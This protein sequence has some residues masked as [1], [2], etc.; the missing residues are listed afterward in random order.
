VFFISG[1]D[2]SILGDAVSKWI[3]KLTARMYS[4]AR[5]EVGLLNRR[6]RLYA[7]DSSESPSHLSPAVH[8][9]HRAYP[10]FRSLGTSDT[11]CDNDI[12]CESFKFPLCEVNTTAGEVFCAKI[13]NLTLDMEAIVD[14]LGPI[15][16]K[17]VSVNDED[18]AG[19]LDK[20]VDPALL[21]LDERL[22]GISDIL[23]KKI[24]VLDIAELFLGAKSGAPTVRLLIKIYRSIKSFATRYCLFFACCICVMLGFV[25]I[26][27][28]NVPFPLLLS[29]FSLL[30]N[31]CPWF[32]FTLK[33][34]SKME[35]F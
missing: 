11:A 8:A 2:P 19:Y 23:K 24:T 18:E 21:V 16:K 1:L 31:S 5:K 34:L 27:L 25:E 6:R 30:S 17:I 29:H 4:Q 28:L 35:E 7:M 9:D 26:H 20:V 10:F 12:L 32:D 14:A 22:P 13:Y 3:P 33:A 15:L